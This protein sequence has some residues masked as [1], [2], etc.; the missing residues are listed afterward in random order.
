MTTAAKLR[1][2][3][4]PGRRNSR[5]GS[6]VV[7]PSELKMLRVVAR[8]INETGTQ[9]SMREIAR[10]LGYT[11]PGYVHFMVKNLERKGFIDHRGGT[12][13]SIIF[14]WREYL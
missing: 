2:N 1:G 5:P 8:S 9:P 10:Q 6:P 14:N 3:R 13:K 11:S 12:S 7:A 4:K